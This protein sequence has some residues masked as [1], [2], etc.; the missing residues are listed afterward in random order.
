L[1][2]FQLFIATESDLAN[3]IPTIVGFCS[4]IIATQT[5]TFFIWPRYLTPLFVLFGT[6]NA[7]SLNFVFSEGL[8]ERPVYIELLL[9]FAIGALY[10]VLA[11]L[12]RK[13]RGWAVSG[14]FLSVTLIGFFG[15]VPIIVEQNSTKADSALP[16]MIRLVEFVRRPNVYFLGFD[17]LMPAALTKRILR[18]EDPPYIDVIRKH[19]GHIIPNLFADEVPTLRFWARLFNLITPSYDEGDEGDNLP[20]RKK[21]IM[22]IKSSAVLATFQ[23]N[24]YATHFTFWKAY[25]GVNN[26]P[27]LTT[28]EFLDPYSTCSFVHNH[29]K[30]FGFLGYCAL[31]EWLFPVIPNGHDAPLVSKDYEKR[32]ARWSA[33]YLKRLRSVTRDSTSRRHFFASHYPDPDHPA[34]RERYIMGIKEATSA[35]ELMLTEIQ[36]SDPTAIVFLFGDHGSYLAKGSGIGYSD[37]PEVVVPDRH[38]IMGAVFGAEACMPYLQ[39]PKGET[40]QTSSR[41]VAGI[42]QCLAGGESPLFTNYDFGKIRQAPD[43]MRFD[44]YAYE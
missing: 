12:T 19:G 33:F 44:N 24:G 8:G 27:F 7:Y 5:L 9:L 40:I 20:G 21:I 3:D 32:S 43:N 36:K 4:L 31:R 17:G 29:A 14:A 22:G 28:Y 6:S 15:V 42:L 35:M 38:G 39:P 16:G 23:H 11:Q 30:R 10:F 37:D 34:T 18:I 2:L 1:W 13:L 25:A 41:V 26:G